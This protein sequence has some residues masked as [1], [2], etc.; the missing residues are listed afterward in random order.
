[1][2]TVICSFQKRIFHAL[3]SR[4]D[5]DGIEFANGV[6]HFK[7][8]Q[9]FRNATIWEACRWVSMSMT[10]AFGH[11]EKGDEVN[12]EIESQT[13]VIVETIERVIADRFPDT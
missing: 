6:L 10:Y 11:L 3:E 13:Q 9:M 2:K 1:M 5:G 8:T 12:I 4:H 7:N